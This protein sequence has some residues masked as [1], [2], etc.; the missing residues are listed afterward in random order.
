MLITSTSKCANYIGVCNVHAH[1]FVFNLDFYCILEMKDL[2]KR[3]HSYIKLKLFNIKSVYM[4]L[5]CNCATV[6]VIGII[7]IGCSQTLLYMH[8]KNC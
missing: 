2:Q 1:V 8:F 4:L 5:K 3:K 7:I 6:T